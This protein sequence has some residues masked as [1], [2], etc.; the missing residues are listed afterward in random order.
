[1]CMNCLTGVELTI[2]QGT[3]VAAFAKAGA[4][5]LHE[6]VSGTDPMVRRL[7]AHEANAAFLAGMGLDPAAVLG[8]AP[9]AAERTTA[10]ARRRRA[11][12]APRPT[13]VRPALAGG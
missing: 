11:S 8:P 10:P 2:M 3:A 12:R 1:M 9:V 7:A 6:R 5:R 4:V 13:V